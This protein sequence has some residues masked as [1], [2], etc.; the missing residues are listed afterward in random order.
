ML[1]LLL[2]RSHIATT[3]S[4]IHTHTTC[5][6]HALHTI[7]LLCLYV[8]GGKCARPQPP[9]PPPFEISASQSGCGRNFLITLPSAFV[10]LFQFHMV[11]RRWR[12]SVR[13]DRG[14]GKRGGRNDIKFRA[15]QICESMPRSSFPV[16][17]FVPSFVASPL[18]SLSVAIPA[19]P[20]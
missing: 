10:S 15:S 20:H 9:H 13:R 7:I 5:P 16:R 8:E 1:I 19:N 2:F 17:S 14:I 6:A 4:H 18:K 3:H 12:D 11:W